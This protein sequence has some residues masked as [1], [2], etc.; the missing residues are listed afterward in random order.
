MMNKEYKIRN[1]K[2]MRLVSVADLTTSCIRQLK[3]T[4][5]E[6]MIFNSFSNIPLPQ[7]R[8]QFIRPTG[9]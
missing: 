2:V 9:N 6:N 8:G 7:K 1:E 3:P 4:A 5:I